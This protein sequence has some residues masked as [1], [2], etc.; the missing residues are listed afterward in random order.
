[1]S[2]T[3]SRQGQRGVVAVMA[4][5]MM[6]TLIMFLAVVVDTGRIFLEKRS[7]QKNADLAALETALLYCRDQ[8]I[9]QLESYATGALG[10]DRNDFRG[11]EGDITV[12]LGQVDAG[13]GNSRAFTPNGLDDTGKAVEVILTRTIPA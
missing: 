9:T 4:A 1:T 2:R 8:D 6:T 12:S 13:E 11:G 10:P 3:A 5:V 7:L